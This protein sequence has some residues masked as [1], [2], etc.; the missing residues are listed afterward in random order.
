M[1]FQFCSLYLSACFRFAT[2]SVYCFYNL[3]MKAILNALYFVLLLVLLFN[4]CRG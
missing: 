3:N 4:A 2:I 1:R